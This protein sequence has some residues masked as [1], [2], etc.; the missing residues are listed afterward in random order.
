MVE[1][2]QSIIEIPTRLVKAYLIKGEKGSILVDT[3]FPGNGKKITKFLI[4]KGIDP[5]RVGLILITHGHIDHYGS[6]RELRELTGAPVAIQELDADGPRKGISAHLYP[7]GLFGRMLNLYA[8]KQRIEA[9]EPDIIL[10]G[11]EDLEKYGI[12]AKVVPTPGHTPGSISV[13]LPEAALVGDLIVGK[14]FFSKAPAYSSFVW[15]REQLRQSV[16]KLL[17][18]SP[19]VFL[20]CHGGP[21]EPQMVARRFL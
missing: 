16:R 2:K 1:G 7:H 3:G 19:K 9:L 12:E 15:D 21:F 17:E 10:K 13:V 18:Y 11:D 4:K 14:F 6:A 20:S 8:R 5:Q